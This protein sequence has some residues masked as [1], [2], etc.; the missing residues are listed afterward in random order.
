[1]SGVLIQRGEET[2]VDN[3]NLK[4]EVSSGRKEEIGETV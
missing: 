1:M 3:V 4:K 2:V